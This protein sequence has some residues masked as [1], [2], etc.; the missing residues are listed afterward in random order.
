MELHRKYGSKIVSISDPD[1]IKPIH[2][3]GAD[4]DKALAKR[5]D[6]ELAGKLGEGEEL[7]A[8]DYFVIRPVEMPVIVRKRVV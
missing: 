6:F 7:Q 1:A 2:G 4:F 8:S 3:Y 5:F